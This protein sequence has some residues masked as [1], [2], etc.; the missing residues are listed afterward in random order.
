ML[1]DRELLGIPLFLSFFSISCLFFS[2]TIVYLI[3]DFFY[4]ALGTG[5]RTFE[6]EVSIQHLE[7]HLEDGRR[8]GERNNEPIISVMIR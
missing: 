8:E 7:K 3:N 5:E 1:L 2:S 4:G 6:N